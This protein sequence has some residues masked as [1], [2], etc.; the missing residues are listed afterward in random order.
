MI[1]VAGSIGAIGEGKSDLIWEI[2]PLGPSGRKLV[3]DRWGLRA[4]LS[5]PGYGARGGLGKK[6]EPD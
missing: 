5:K 4:S 1:Q 2:H 3:K 6:L